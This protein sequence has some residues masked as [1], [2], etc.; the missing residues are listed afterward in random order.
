MKRYN[1]FKMLSSIQDEF[2]LESM[3]DYQVIRAKKSRSDNPFF[4]FLN[5]GWGAACI[6]ALVAVGVM[7]FIIRAGQDPVTPPATTAEPSVEETTEVPTEEPTEAPTETEAETDPYFDPESLDLDTYQGMTPD[8]P[9]TLSYY[10]LGDGTCWVTHITVN[11]LYEGQYTVEIPETSPE[12]ET[13]VGLSLHSSYNIPTYVSV[14]DFMKLKAALIDYYR[15]TPEQSDKEVE[16]NYYYK[17]F[18]SYFRLTDAALS[19][20]PELKE[21]LIAEYPLCEY[22]GIYAF[23]HT[24]TDVEYATLSR[25]IAEVAPWYTPEWCYADLLKMKEAA[26]SYGVT[27]PRLEQFLSLHSD[28]LRDAVTVKLPKTLALETW[29]PKILASAG[30]SSLTYDGTMEEF[31]AA[32]DVEN[33]TVCTP[34]VVHCTDG[35]ISYPVKE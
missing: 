28:H 7:A 1:R 10:S 6:C 11:I 29:A 32:S 33:S 34:L 4:R 14:D 35:D 26:D 22:L 23:D 20:T 27:D 16:N 19:S 24:T 12:G 5:S 21:D 9:Y 8:F 3:P 2:I 25:T 31:R 18:M 13:V 30:I 15:D 17:S